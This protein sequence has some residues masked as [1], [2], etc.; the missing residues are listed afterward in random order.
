MISSG[1]AV[2]PSPEITVNQEAFGQALNRYW[3]V[4]GGDLGDLLRQQTGLVVRRVIDLTPPFSSTRLERMLGSGKGSFGNFQARTIGERAVERDIRR[5]FIPVSE[6]KDWQKSVKFRKAQAA[7]DTETIAKLLK[8]KFH[9]DRVTVDV[10]AEH[11]KKSRSHDGRV[12]RKP[13]QHLVLVS[14]NIIKYVKRRQ[15]QVGYA[16]SGWNEAHRKFGVRLK[17]LSG[18]IK[19]HHG[20]GF[21]ED[22]TRNRSANDMYTRIGNSVPFIQRKGREL[23]IM[24]RALAD[25]TKALNA[26]VE[27]ILR[28][29]AK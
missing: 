26:N 29:H 5:V 18:W 9:F 27:R 24:E 15:A 7:N 16:K 23:R 25:Q 22:Q 8:G 14:E 4:V 1:L 12:K 19:A 17:A 13:H 6:L 11:H 21:A 3:K 10:D 20:A 28:N 2:P